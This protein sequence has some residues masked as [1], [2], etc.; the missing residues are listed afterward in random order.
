LK[1][2]ISV[3]EVNKISEKGQKEL[4]KDSQTIITPAAKDRAEELGI[5]IKDG[6]DQESQESKKT[7]ES[8]EIEEQ[9]ISNEIP[10][11]NQMSVNPELIAKIVKNVIAGMN[12]D[13]KSCGLQKETDPSGLCLIKGD[14][15]VCEPFDTGNPNDKVGIKEILS[16]EESPNMGLGFMTIEKSSFSWDMK[17]EEID[18]IVEGTL[19]FT[20]DGKTYTG[21]AGD[22]FYIPK[23]TKVTFSTPD[24]TKFFFVVYP[25]NWAELCGYKG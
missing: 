3:N 7:Q 4:Y 16:I 17:Y 12:L 5:K 11:D 14:S 21:K 1:V 24:R 6:R 10:V 23:D 18:Y 13:T 22:V 25:A 19:E 8:Q 9:I 20:V 2:L 15:V